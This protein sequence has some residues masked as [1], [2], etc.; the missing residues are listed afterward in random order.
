MNAN[1][2]VEATSKDG[3]FAELADISSRMIDAHGK[4]FC[5]GALV[6][7]A[8]FVAEGK[9]FTEAPKGN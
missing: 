2:N 1:P 5:M 7:A 4:D 6:L 8:R 9:T 3:F